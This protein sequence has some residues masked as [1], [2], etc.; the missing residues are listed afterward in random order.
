MRGAVGGVEAID[1]AIADELA[2]RKRL[3]LGVAVA[4]AVGAAVLLGIVPLNPR[5][6]VFGSL[7]SAAAAA[8]LCGSIGLGFGAF[9]VPALILLDVDA[10]IAVASSLISQFIVVP[11]GGV[12]HASF[13]HVRGRIVAPLL[14]A[15]VAG[16]FLGAQFSLAIDATL[17]A[18]LIALSTVLMGVLVVARNSPE[19]K[20][21]AVE[22][23][24][25]SEAVVAIGL[26][27]GFAAAAFGTGWGPVGVCLLLLIGIAP[28]LAIGSSVIA[29]APLAFSAIIAYVVIAGPQEIVDVDVL[30]PI[31][32][33]GIVGILA[34]SLVT[35]RLRDR[36]LRR[37]VGVGIVALGL[38]VFLK[39]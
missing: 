9:L 32:A 35:R 25:R 28:K 10:R 15:G 29:R 19:T 38:L 26:I 1:A 37:F 27:A 22:R 17:L 31:V 6:L 33:G 24:V 11:L 7:A 20:V 12:S 8:F 21:V 13:G 2:V 30:L 23:V 5:V 4:S 39:V 18:V 34:G 3:L 36:W 14:G 16:T